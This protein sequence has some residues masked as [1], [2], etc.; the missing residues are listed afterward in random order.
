MKKECCESPEKQ[1]SKQTNKHKSCL[2]YQVAP[3]RFHQDQET[4]ERPKLVS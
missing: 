4:E 3:L 2:G 1:R